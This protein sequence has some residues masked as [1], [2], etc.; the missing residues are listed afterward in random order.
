MEK[1]YIMQMTYVKYSLTI[2]E[3]MFKK[4]QFLRQQIIECLNFKKLTVNY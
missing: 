1:L 2:L 4:E 3:K